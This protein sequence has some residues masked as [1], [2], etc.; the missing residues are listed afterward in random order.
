MLI[1]DFLNYQLNNYG[2][3]SKVPYNEVRKAWPNNENFI[4]VGDKIDD[5]RE[6][7]KIISGEEFKYTNGRVKEENFYEYIEK[8]FPENAFKL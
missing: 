6:K 1:D 8:I 4:A 5:L 3:T 2:I 7:Y